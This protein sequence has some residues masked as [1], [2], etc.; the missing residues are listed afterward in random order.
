MT[1]D[2]MKKNLVRARP[3]SMALPD[4]FMLKRELLRG[5]VLQNSLRRLKVVRS[6]PPLAT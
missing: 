4:L 3:A 5:L 6:Q 2:E 1:P